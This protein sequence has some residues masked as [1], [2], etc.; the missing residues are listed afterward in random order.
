VLAAQTGEIVISND[1]EHDPHFKWNPFLP[2]TRSEMAIP[3][4]L[5]SRLLG[6]LDFQSDKTNFFTDDDRAVQQTLADQIAVAIRNARLYSSIRNQGEISRILRD[7]ALI[8]TSSHDR[9][10]ILENTLKETAQ[11]LPFSAA[12]V[13][14]QDDADEEVMRI[15]AWVGYEPFGVSESIRRL[16]L[17]VDS[18]PLMAEMQREKGVIVIPDTREDDRWGTIPGYEWIRSWA[19]API[20][21]RGN[22]VGRL[23]LDHVQPE[24]YN[25]DHISILEVLSREI[26]LAVDN[27]S[28]FESERAQ[29][30]MA[31]TMR[32]IG[33]VLTS[34]LDQ[35]DILQLVLAQVARVLPYSAAGV[36]LDDGTGVFNVAA[37][38]GYDAFDAEDHIQNLRFFAGDAHFFLNKDEAFIISDTHQSDQW[39]IV[40]GFDWIRS[41]A[42]APIVVRGQLIGKVSLDHAQPGFYNTRQHKSLLESLTTQ[43]SIAVGNARL[44]EAERQRRQEIEALQRGNISL[45]ASLELTEVL[46]AILGAAFDL[47]PA[48]DANVFLYE[49]D[50]LI[51]GAGMNYHHQ[52][53]DKP[54]AIPRPDGL[55]YSVAQTGEN[56]IVNDM[57]SHPLFKDYR[58]APFNQ[59]GAIIGIAL[60]IGSRVV[61]VMN[62]AFDSPAHPGTFDTSSLQLLANQA[63]I[64]IENAR[65]YKA[66]QDHAAQLES[67]VEERTAELESERAQLQTILD[68]MAEGVIYDEGLEIK[69]INRQLSEMIGSDL[70]HIH[71]Y[72]ELVRFMVP[73]LVDAEKIISR[74]YRIPRQAESWQQDV[75]L[76]RSD[77]SEFDASVVCASVKDA[78][79]MISGAVTIVREIGQEKALQIQRERF[80]S[81]ASHELRTP[82]TNLQTRLYLLQRRPER[83]QEHLRVIESVAEQ[84]TNLVEDLLDVSRFK[85]GVIEMRSQAVVLQDIILRV[86]DIQRAESDRKGISLLTELPE[87]PVVAEVDVRRM[88]QVFTN[89]ITNAINYTEEGGSITVTLTSE[90]DHSAVITVQDTGV[91]IAPHLLGQVFQP[92]FR[93]SEG[94]AVGTGLGLSITREIVDAHH[95]T[96]SVDSVKGQGSAFTV[97]LPLKGR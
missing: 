90:L 79:E 19:A 55:T 68:S 78:D 28:L 8:L 88:E 77:G 20:I 94:M 35:G 33:L 75:R 48:R 87:T 22:L 70:H 54:I 65:L 31:E 2:D 93:A 63:S 39:T 89:L 73:S 24:T 59:L 44:F 18:T 32:D 41:W 97:T 52:R 71:Q 47:S 66:V 84:M 43:V 76:R 9:K 1:V 36:W 49:N 95:G 62:L 21:S 57:D 26:S 34:S 96:L 27:A 46:D 3:I 69:Y 12:G 38:F 42:S 10:T 13:W 30:E 4:V 92:F 23:T 5:D 83:L 11:V 61:G 40:E 85:R 6:I 81:H 25:P 7:I 15:V 67:R 72:E 53:F 37:H 51:F 91:G 80:I 60:K 45:T 17:R 56:I 82:L 50:T 74:A 29:R 16:R 14:L 58:P 86:T 64:A